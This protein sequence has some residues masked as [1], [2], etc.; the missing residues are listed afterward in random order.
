MKVS[1]HLYR[2]GERQDERGAQLGREQALLFESIERA[3]C[4][5]ESDVARHGLRVSAAAIRRHAAPAP[6]YLSELTA[7]ARRCAWQWRRHG[8]AFSKG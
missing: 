4:N 8:A 6:S 2:V 3:L 7:L 5:V 1:D